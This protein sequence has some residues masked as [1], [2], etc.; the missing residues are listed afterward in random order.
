MPIIRP[1]PPQP[2][3][4]SLD[5]P[6]TFAEFAERY[7]N[8]HARLHKES[9]KQDQ[10]R[11][12]KYLLP[13]FADTPLSEITRGMMSIL[14]HDIG[15]E[16]PYQANRVKEQLSAMIELAKVWELLPENHPNPTIGIRD[17]E[18]MHR[19]RWLRKS[20]VQ[21]L[22]QALQEE[23]CIY[24]KAL[25][26]L[27]L[28][29]GARKRELMKIKWKDVDLEEGY[30]RI[31]KPKN[32]QTHELPLSSAAHLMLSNLPRIN[33]N[34]YVFPGKRQGKPYSNIDKVWRRIRVRAD[35]LDVRIH[36]IRRT[37][38]AWLAQEGNSLFLI[39]KVL[40]HQSEDAT[41]IYAHLS[42]NCVKAALERHGEKIKPMLNQLL[43]Q[44][45]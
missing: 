20:E 38:G 13:A 4:N 22:L 35:L 17:F 28:L 37:V 12:R 39:G 29:T 10:T 2:S 30:I 44:D 19:K 18:E 45:K 5:P 24:I 41:R 15:E 43:L 40:N 26:V 11:L 3:N 31:L 7:I 33:G 25:F 34:E 36:D 16:F 27:Y 8:R 9:W 1:I 32:R 42:D 21:N 6:I 14:H 23:S